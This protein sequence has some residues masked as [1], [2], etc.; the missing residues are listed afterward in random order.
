[1]R[2]HRAQ[3]L[4]HLGESANGAKSGQREQGLLPSR[5]H[6]FGHSQQTVQGESDTPGEEDGSEQDNGGTCQA[7]QLPSGPDYGCLLDSDPNQE[8][9]NCDQA[10]TQ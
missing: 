6:P 8:K 9:G 3:F 2:L 10:T 1:M 5:R 4:E 7:D